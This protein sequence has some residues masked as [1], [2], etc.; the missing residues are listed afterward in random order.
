LTFFLLEG[1]IMN[2]YGS[3]PEMADMAGLSVILFIGVALIGLV[4]TAGRVWIWSK[5]CSK[6]G[7]PWALGLLMLVPLG[8]AFLIMY[9]AFGQWPIHRELEMLRLQR[10]LGGNDGEAGSGAVV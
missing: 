4:L 10:D 6:T 1:F 3:M 2:A 9:V 8:D 7:H 5:I